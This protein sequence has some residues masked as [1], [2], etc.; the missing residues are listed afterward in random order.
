MTRIVVDPVEL[1]K[2]ADFAGEAADVYATVGRG[3][4]EQVLPPMP[5]V[6]AS[7]IGAGLARAAERLESLGSRLN[8]QAYLLRTRASIIE[9]EV[10]SHLLLNVGRDADE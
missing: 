6:L 9:N 4:V 7:A 5:P 3:L 8:G 2:L 10:A 1:S